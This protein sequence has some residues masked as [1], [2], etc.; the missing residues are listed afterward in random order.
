MSPPTSQYLD[1]LGSLKFEFLSLN[2][3]K[4]KRRRREEEEKKKIKKKN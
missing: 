3:C 2:P 1:D 4:R